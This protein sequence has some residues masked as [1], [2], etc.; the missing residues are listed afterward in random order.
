MAAGL[1]SRPNARRYV[2]FVGFVVLLC[3][4]LLAERDLGALLIYY[5][6]T[7]FMYFAATSNL[8][9]T[10][11]G[12][13]AG[14][15]GSVLA[16]RA[17]PYVQTR[18]A[19]YQNPWSHP[20]TSGWQSIQALIAIASGGAFGM[21]L[22]LGYPRNIPLY[23]SDFIFSAIGEEFGMIFSLCVLAIYVLMVMRGVTVAMS[24][25][26][27]FHALLAF[28]IVTMLALQTLI[29]IGGNI[30]LIPLTGVTL[31]FVSAGGSS[32]ISCMGMMGL[33]LG[34]SS[35]NA[36]DEAEDLKN[37]EWREVGAP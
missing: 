24:A 3:A 12:F 30:K 28:G 16:Y 26:S 29:H 37:R 11:A 6:T 20:E 21:G 23:H 35:V 2:L 17:L 18:I 19:I 8:P 36:N 32:L 27:S 33:L 15:V 34:V 14:G 7:L 10:L 5:L 25:R 1:S 31:P 13:L 9:L 22:G 4:L